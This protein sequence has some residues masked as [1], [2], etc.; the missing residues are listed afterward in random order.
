MPPMSAFE[1]L[2]SYYATV[3]HELGHLTGHE[4][5]L[6]R[7]LITRF[8]TEAYAAEE[9]VAELTSAFL[10]RAR[11]PGELRHSGYIDHWIKLLRS[12]PKA[13]FTAA[14]K[15]SQAASYLRSLSETRNEVPRLG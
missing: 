11:R 7:K 15:A 1:N 5:R 4:N 13:I 6:D 14:S 2:S 12:D 3:F 10:R 8:G 9:L